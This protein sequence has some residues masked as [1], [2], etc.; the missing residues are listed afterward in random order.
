MLRWLLP[1]L[2]AV[3]ALAQSSSTPETV[4]ANIDIHQTKIPAIIQMYGEPEGVYAAPDP[5]PV[6]TKQYKWG[7]LTLTL[8]LLTEPG[9][10]GDVIKTIQIEGQGDGKP[11]S[12]T[13]RGLKLGDKAQQIDKI[14]GASPQ[15]STARIE[16]PDG[17][18]L[19]IHVND[20]ERVDRLELSVK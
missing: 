4:L 2:F 5:Y 11:I 1:I 6:G 18:V 16:W 13:G 14:Y 10:D 20:K 9:K 19:L 7:R 12:R 3:P 8:R 15:N 17:T